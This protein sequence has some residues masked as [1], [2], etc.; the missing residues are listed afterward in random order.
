MKAIPGRRDTPQIQGAQQ[1]VQ[2]EP[3]LKAM[4]CLSIRLGRMMGMTATR[5]ISTTIITPGI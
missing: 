2:L 5:A 3:L 1:A 4:E